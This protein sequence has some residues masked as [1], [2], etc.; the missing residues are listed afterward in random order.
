MTR[1]RQTQRVVRGE[2]MQ[3][4]KAGEARSYQE[5]GRPMS[6][7]RKGAL[8]HRI[9]RSADV[10]EIDAGTPSLRTCRG[11]RLGTPG[12]P[13]FERTKGLIEQALI[14]LDEIGAAANELSRE[15]RGRPEIDPAVSG[16]RRPRADQ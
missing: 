15:L 1:D 4:I 14:I 8:P 7:R 10:C 13:F 12:H 11:D 3:R 6:L 2:R 5:T 9:R 16:Q